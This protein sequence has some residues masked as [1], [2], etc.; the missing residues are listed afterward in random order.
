MAMKH[1]SKEVVLEF[2]LPE[3]KKE[4]IKVRFA[5]NSVVIKAEKKLEKKIQRK[6]F[7]HQEKIQRNFNYA[8][9]LPTIN[10]KKAKAEFKKGI[11]RIS[12]ERV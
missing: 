11:L 2:S 6:D 5:K 9:T 3:F 4:D 10:P 8:T 12:V 7:F 1:N